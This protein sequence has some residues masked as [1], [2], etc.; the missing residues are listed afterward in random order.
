MLAGQSSLALLAPGVAA[1]PAFASFL[2]AG[3]VLAR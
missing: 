1:V 3:V 2:V